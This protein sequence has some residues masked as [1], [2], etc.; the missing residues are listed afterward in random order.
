MGCDD[1]WD[2]DD[3]ISRETWN[4]Q[5]RKRKRAAAFDKLLEHL[6]ENPESVNLLRN[7]LGLTSITPDVIE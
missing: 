2:Y 5:E 4:V 7:A 6:K 3:R 1:Y